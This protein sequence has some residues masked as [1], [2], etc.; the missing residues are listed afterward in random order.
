[1]IQIGN[2]VGTFYLTQEDGTYPVSDD[3]TNAYGGPSFSNIPAN[4]EILNK[5]I[6]ALD[7]SVGT[8]AVGFWDITAAAI[9]TYTACSIDGVNQATLPITVTTA[10]ALTTAEE[11]RD[12][13]NAFTPTS[14][15]NYTATAVATATGAR[16]TFFTNALT[17]DFDGDVVLLTGS[18]GNTGTATNIMGGRDAGEYRFRMWYDTGINNFSTTTLPTTALDVT[19]SIVFRGLQHVAAESTAT[20]VSNAINVER[21]G[22]QQTIIVTGALANPDLTTIAYP[23]AHIGDLLTLKPASNV[24]PFKLKNNAINVIGRDMQFEG[25]ED[26]I[27]LR[28]TQQNPLILE[29]VSRTDQVFAQ[30]SDEIERV[31]INS[32][33]TF[34][35]V[36]NA[37][38]TP[39]VNTTYR[40]NVTITA[41]QTLTA[42]YNFLIDSSN[43]RNGDKGI[44]NGNGQAITTGSNVLSI[45]SGLVIR[46]VDTALAATGQ[47]RALWSFD[48][49]DVQIEI[50]PDFSVQNA[51]FIRPQQFKGNANRREVVVPVSFEAGEQAQYPVKFA[52]DCN[53]I[54]I[55]GTTT[56]QLAATDNGVID[57]QVSAVSVATITYA[58]SEPINSQVSATPV[59]SFPIPV[60]GGNTLFFETSKITPGGKALVYAVIELV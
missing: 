38:G 9:G 14:G 19:D 58:P 17:D 15:P 18:V 34:D 30:R 60:T 52:S 32:S 24:V 8:E 41:P 44:I 1:M 22:S 21:K 12:A 49:T 31:A 43:M 25:L 51:S 39:P 2:N 54:E 47:W 26:A 4:I 10:V 5:I 55:V 20:I 37:T 56:S 57:I 23:T 28:V 33:G 16:V 29:Q 6:T 59:T 35:I 3:I 7:P 27:T 11:I 53:I 48:G 46:N 13:V 40:N 45:Q 36:P 50:A 42:N